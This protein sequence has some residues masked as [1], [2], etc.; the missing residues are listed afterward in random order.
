[1]AIMPLYIAPLLKV[2]Q[3]GHDKYAVLNTRISLCPACMLVLGVPSSV[4][5]LLAGD[6][7]SA[8][9]ASLRRERRMAVLQPSESRHDHGQFV[10]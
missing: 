10:S 6:G 7:D 4:V 2:A 3:C 1:M 8:A 5:V 9:V